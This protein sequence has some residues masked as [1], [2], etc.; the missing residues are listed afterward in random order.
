MVLKKVTKVMIVA[1]TDIWERRQAAI[2]SQP[3]PTPFATRKIYFKEKTFIPLLPI[4]FPDY[5]S[6]EY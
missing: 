3:N 6:G 5:L 1:C 2:I 4:F